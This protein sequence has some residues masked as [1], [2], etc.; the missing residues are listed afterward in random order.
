MPM[1]G[2]ASAGGGSKAGDIR[3]GGAFVEISAKDSLTKTLAGLKARVMA[4]A[5]G[6][7][8]AGVGALGAGAALA[9]PLAGLFKGGVDR[10]EE[11]SK[12][13]EELGF[14]VEQMQ[15]LKYAADVA[16]VSLDDVLKNPGRF[17]ALMDSAPLMDPNEIKA[18]VQ[19]NQ[20]WRKSI[21][22]LQGAML[23]LLQT[24]FPIIK[25]VGEFVRVNRG[26]VMTAVLVAGALLGVGSA[27]AVVGPGLLAI[28]GIVLK[29]VSSLGI[30]KLTIIGVF[31]YLLAGTDS[32]KQAIASLSQ[33]FVNA[34]ATFGEMWGGIIEAVKK[35]QLELAFKI[36][37]AGIKVIWLGMLVDMGK[38]FA[39]FVEDNRTKLIALGALM[40]AQKGSAIGS[41][42]G[43]KG[44]AAGIILGLAVGGFGANQTVDELKGL[45]DNPRLEADRKK[46]EMELKAIQKKIAEAP[47]K[48]DAAGVFTGESTSGGMLPLIAAAKGS[49]RVADAGQ[50]F[51]GNGN[52]VVRE[53]KKANEKADEVIVIQNRI[54]AALGITK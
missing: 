10:A 4:F 27:L 15:R 30:F 17:K 18:S 20:E 14:G 28:G 7:K 24:L 52:P 42:L 33:A 16:G 32:G 44:K 19:A 6:L 1:A 45:G 41:L 37:A 40:G 46:A 5:G 23:P 29:A 54:A 25:S 47:K 22:S 8:M 48:L 49:F 3:A 43:P 35:G 26:A 13:A 51:G 38:A 36:M 11:I 12:M 9:A 21:I 50:Q 2:G 31:A 39:Q 34:G 53:L